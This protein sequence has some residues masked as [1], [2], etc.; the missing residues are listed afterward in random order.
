MKS[1]LFY[2]L[3]LSYILIGCQKD[4]TCECNYSNEITSYRIKDK[5]KKDAQKICEEKVPMGIIVVTGNSC[6]IAD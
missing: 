3:L 5:S 6:H 4:W 2:T 1:R